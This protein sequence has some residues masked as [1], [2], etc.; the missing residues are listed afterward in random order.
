VARR[1]A[2]STDAVVQAAKDAFWRLGY[3][4][5]AISELEK[6]SGL[7]RSSLYQAFNSKED[8]FSQALDA[9]IRGFVGP[10]L[11]PMESPR[12]QPGAA[13]VFVRRLA[14]LFQEEGMPRSHGDLWI[15][16]IHERNGGNGMHVDT[17]SAEFWARLTSAY[18]N[19]LRHDTP[20]QGNVNGDQGNGTDT[21]EDRACLLASA[22]VGCWLTVRFDPQKAVEGCNAMLDEIELWRK[23]DAGP[24]LA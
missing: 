3:S 20:R 15:N 6:A 14:E 23:L 16:A 17:R 2:Y 7:S 24:Q 10:L 12:P 18:A 21:A 11:A 1:R 5:A 9:Y 19:A 8:L 13:E 4:G 22:T